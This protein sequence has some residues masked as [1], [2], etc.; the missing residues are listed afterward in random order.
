MLC[1]NDGGKDGVLVDRRACSKNHVLDV[2]VGMEFRRL[3]NLHTVEFDQVD[4]DLLD[5]NLFAIG[6]ELFNE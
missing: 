1:G 6:H 4:D 3:G 2:G 5:D